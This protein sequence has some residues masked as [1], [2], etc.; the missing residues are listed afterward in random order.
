LF[1]GQ[2]GC[3]GIGTEDK[4]SGGRSEAECDAVERQRERKEDR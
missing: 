1:V 4:C 3:Q 2:D